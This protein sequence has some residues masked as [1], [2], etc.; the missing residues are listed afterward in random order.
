MGFPLIVQ[1][2]NHHKNSDLKKLLFLT[3]L[4]L[5]THL[6]SQTLR[7]FYLQEMSEQQIPVFV[8]HPNEGAIIF[9]TAIIGLTV[10]SST[11]GVTSIQSEASKVTV[12]LKP[13]R[14][15]LTLKAPGF[16]EKKL[17]VENLSAKQARFY[18][19][20]EKE[21]N[22][23]AS[24]GS[25]KVQTQPDGA[26]M[27]IEGFPT[28]KQLTP[29]DLK[30]FEAKKYKINL[31]KPDYYPLDT[32]IEI[33]SG[34]KQSGL[35]KLRSMYGTLSFRASVP[36]KVKLNDQTL[37]VGQELNNQRLRDGVYTVSLNDFRFDPYQETVV[38][39]PGAT[40]IL[41]LPLVKRV[42][43]FLIKTIPDG[44]QIKIE[45]KPDFLKFSPFELVDFEAKKY[46]IN[47]NKLDYFPLD[48][49]I[50]VQ[51][52][53]NLTGQFSL[54]SMFGTLSIKSPFPV[55][56]RINNSIEE[57]RSEPRVLPLKVGEYTLSVNDPR[58]FT[59]TETITI[60]SGQTTIKEIPLKSVF[61]NLV[62]KSAIPVKVKINDQTEE[63]GSEPRT[64]SL[65]LGDYTLSVN[66]SRVDPWQE[67][68]SLGS[69]E[70][71]NI[72][73]PLIKRV[74]YLQILH[75]DGFDFT[76]G[77]EIKSKKPGTQLIEF[78]EGS[79]KAEVKR[80]GFQTVTFSFTLK[81]GDV[82]NWEPTFTATTIP[83]KI[84]TEPSGATVLLT[85]GSDQ[86]VLGFTPLEEQI[87]VGEVEFLV[88]KEGLKD[89][90][91][92][93]KLEEGKSFS[94]KI[95]L[96]N[97]EETTKIKLESEPSGA[98]VLL[99]R[100]PDHE[101][102]GFTPLEEQ[103][104]VGEVEFLL[105]KEG[106]K[107]YQFKAKLEEGKPFYK[108]INLANP[109]ADNLPA[110]G[111]GNVYKTVIIG[112]QEWTVENLKTTKYN[113]GTAITKV[114]DNSKWSNTT[115][116]AYCAYE[117]DEGKVSTYGYL[118][119]WQ[120]V[121][122]GKLAPK[123]G[124]WR[125]PTDADW[126]RLTNA[127]G[128]EGNAGRKLKA[129]TGWNSSENGSNDY[130]FSALPGGRRSSSNGAFS[131]LGYNGFWWSSAA[132]GSS[133]WSR[134]MISNSTSVYR[135]YDYQKDGFSVRLVRDIK[136]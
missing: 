97:P 92:K 94:K 77:S 31:I 44:A 17:P 103:L 122:T 34:L 78:F 6:F 105:K 40:K 46:K 53:V 5:P 93:V 9:Y 60:L 126:D 45:G 108:K 118:Y 75:P 16:I 67:K 135:S 28:F 13:E 84:E 2:K 74:G 87:A 89:F 120:A 115:N 58:F 68:I 48:T 55:K 134:G 37:D 86:E 124:G 96:A 71:K 10:E 19:L 21:E 41:E 125:V 51:R 121:N 66:D 32:L 50:E 116:G 69:G 102:L 36:V 99:T 81:K 80:P 14:Q 114:A 3:L 23:S 33:R 11:G 62:L 20:N 47:L 29:F 56:V 132:Y 73:L 90:S 112:K 117:N 131:S 85:R 49:L 133:A 54:R 27:K 15:I 7:E 130:S 127:V 98:T 57:V 26:I 30:D 83:V 70:T 72:D 12:F 65:R 8:D 119:N 4:F 43:N 100:G 107:D 106:V 91:F 18:R 136:Q 110:D 104:A 79:Y 59:Y 38:L 128:G 61:G 101:V 95:N 82:V 52:G 76:A 39:E 129:K 42:G 123:S 113:D 35:F 88:K 1:L 63:I 25:Y 22:Y 24:T 111:D 64:F 109:E